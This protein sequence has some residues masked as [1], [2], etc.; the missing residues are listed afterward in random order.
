MISLLRK[1]TRLDWRRRVLL[2]EAAAVHVAMVGWLRLRPNGPVV[3]SSAPRRRARQAADVEAIAWAVRTAAART[4]GSTCLS[5]ACAT[6]LMLARRGVAA[7][8]EFGVAKN[9]VGSRFE[10]AA[11][12]FRARS[13]RLPTPFFHAW[14]VCDGRVVAGGETADAYRSLEPCS[15]TAAR[16]ANSTALAGR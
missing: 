6:R 13:K 2:V 5:V 12:S 1:L 7:Q 8:I 3:R 9:G 14:L 4:P 15:E 16:I 11:P 10:R